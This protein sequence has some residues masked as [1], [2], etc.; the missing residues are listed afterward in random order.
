MSL[1]FYFDRL[2]LQ[3]KLGDSFSRAVT[4]GFLADKRIA[5]PSSVYPLHHPLVI[6]WARSRRVA[7]SKIL[8][9]VMYK[10]PY[11]FMSLP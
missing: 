9:R 7:N 3:P 8:M 6:V 11:I 5:R 1:Q 2:A 4:S 10:T